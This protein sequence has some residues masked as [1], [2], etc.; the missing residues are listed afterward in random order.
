MTI[1]LMM[2]AAGLLAQADTSRFHQE[3]DYRIEASV[4][5][6]TDILHGRARLRSLSPHLRCQK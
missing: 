4:E 6:G 1:A 5:E 2:L 3:V